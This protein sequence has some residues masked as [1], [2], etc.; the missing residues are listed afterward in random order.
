VSFS[1]YPTV[2][3]YGLAGDLSNG[4]TPPGYLYPGI[5]VAQQRIANK[6]ADYPD[7]GFIYYRAQQPALLFGFFANFT[8][9]PGTGNSTIVQVFKNTEPT[10]FVIGYGNTESGT[11]FNY[12]GSVYFSTNEGIALRIST[13]GT[14]NTNTTHDITAQVD[15]F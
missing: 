4:P 1:Q 11:K 10:Q 14:F 9:G 2:L 6:G 7:P 13:T 3:S 8:G 5:G 15:F 12:D